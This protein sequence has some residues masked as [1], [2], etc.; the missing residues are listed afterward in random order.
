MPTVLKSGSLILLEPS[1]PVQACSGIALPLPLPLQHSNLCIILII[2]YIHQRMHTKRY[3]SYVR[4]RKPLRI[5]AHSVL[6]Q[7]VTNAKQYKH[8]HLILGGFSL[9]LFTLTIYTHFCFSCVIVYIYIYICV[10][11]CV[12]VC[13]C[14]YIYIYIYIFR[15]FK[16]TIL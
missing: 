2:G 16:E 10:C 5:S 12:C 13:V 6:P 3:K 1:G 7:L 9:P 4:L 14:I 15:L 11:V 8:Q